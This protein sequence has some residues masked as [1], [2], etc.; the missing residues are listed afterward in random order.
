MRRQVNSTVEDPQA[1]LPG[2][3][4]SFQ[5]GDFNGKR[6]AGRPSWKLLGASRR[7]ISTLEPIRI[8][9]KRMLLRILSAFTQF[10][11]SCKTYD[12]NRRQTQRID[13]DPLLGYNLLEE[14]L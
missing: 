5:E 12:G 7:V 1:D 8:F 4:R 10:I 2:S 11:L 6:Y 3:F 9:S 13:R 14:F